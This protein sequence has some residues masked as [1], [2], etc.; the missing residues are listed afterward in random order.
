MSI[1]FLSN[2]LIA[3]VNYQLLIYQY[4][5]ITPLELYLMHNQDYYLP[6]SP[7][8]LPI[9]TY[10]NGHQPNISITSHVHP[11]T[12]SAGSS[13]NLAGGRRLA[14]RKDEAVCSERV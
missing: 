4:P 9:F 14:R 13:M 10:Q 5:T 7:H 6:C 2:C 8:I 1:Y 3:A 11:T 12:R